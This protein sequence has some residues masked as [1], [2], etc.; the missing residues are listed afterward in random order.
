M[1]FAIIGAGRMAEE[2]AKVIKHLGHNIAVAFNNEDDNKLIRFKYRFG[3]ESI[4]SGLDGDVIW[5]IINSEKPDGIILAIDWLETANMLE[6]FVNSKIPVLVEKPI[7]LTSQRLRTLFASSKSLPTKNVMVG[8]NRRFYSFIPIIKKAIAKDMLLS[9]EVN[10][11]EKL[12]KYTKEGVR[13][14]YE[15]PLLY[16]AS[17]VLDLLLYTLGNITVFNTDWDRKKQSLHAFLYNKSYTPI[18]FSANFNTPATIPKLAF[19]FVKY[20]LI[21][22]PI[23]CMKTIKYEGKRYSYLRAS[24]ESR[25]DPFK[26]GIKSQMEYFIER[27]INGKKTGHIIKGADLYDAAKVIE[28]SEALQQERRI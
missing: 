15:Y 13:K 7:C 5:E 25:F 12:E 22:E 16:S 10:L 9:V 8:Y 11:P 24:L 2:H 21:L 19:H 28:L 6:W 20:S 26:P 14:V 23:E 1:N 3:V 4:Y 17:H 27:Y 18:H